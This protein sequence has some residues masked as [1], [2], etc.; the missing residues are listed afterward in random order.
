MENMKLEQ[1]LEELRK[2]KERKFNQTVELI[3]NLRKFDIKR[4]SVNTFINL[5]HK[6][7]DK[8]VC[9]FIDMKSKLIDT[10]PKNAFIN[11]K[12]KKQVKKL[13]NEYDFFISSGP[14]MTSVATVFGR[15]LGPAGK[16]PSPKLGII[17]NE[18]EDEI[19]KLVDKINHM[20][21][22]NTKEP[23]IKIAIAKTSMSD[24]QIAENIKTAYDVI[25]NE[26]P[27][28]NENIKSVLVKFTMTK[29]IK[30]TM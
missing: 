3:I 12:D 18:T 8:K 28:K 10:I 9:G 24:A 21:K 4:N 5:P 25:L 7:R 17:L 30:I 27:N 15:V 2:G 13:V 14:N 22:I 1:A 26:L 20:I 19:K 23:S 6:I 29:P 16:M 11:Y